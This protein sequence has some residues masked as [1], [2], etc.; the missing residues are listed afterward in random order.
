[1]KNFKFIIPLLLLWIGH[2]KALGNLACLSSLNVDLGVSCQITLTPEEIGVN[3]DPAYNYVLVP[4]T[5]DCYDVGRTITVVLEQRNRITGAFVNSCFS[6]VTITSR[7]IPNPCER[8]NVYCY[9]S[10]NVRLNDEG[11]VSLT[12][13]MLSPVSLEG[14][15]YFVY[16]VSP[17]ILDCGNIGNNEVRLSIISA[18]FP[19]NYC[20]MNVNV[21]DDGPFRPTC[22]N[23]E[24]DGINFYPADLDQIILQPGSL[25]SFTGAYRLTSESGNPPPARFK[26]LLSK[27]KVPDDKDLVVNQQV[28]QFNAKMKNVSG[29]FTIPKNLPAGKYY[30]VSDVYSLNK[31][32]RYACPAVVKSIQIG[33]LQK[34][35][36]SKERSRM[37][38]DL[39]NEHLFYPNPFTA[40][41]N[42]NP[43]MDL[44]QIRTIEVYDLMGTC[45]SK[46][47]KTQ[48]TFDLS[49]L[50]PGTYLIHLS[51]LDGTQMTEKLLKIY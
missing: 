51:L 38:E 32:S 23:I 39:A 34:S 41:I 22:Y 47:D 18:C 17:N 13:E 46:L 16:D 20:I 26:M 4:S 10:V 14:N 29:K 24:T 9:S 6:N 35:A 45:I 11:Y 49:Q 31:K 15:P 2:Y 21:I 27:D 50:H 33:K 7:T 44:D 40:S 19:V 12:P 42:L 25:I 5:F 3:L 36:E 48:T 30:L 28:V 1:M 37:S 8:M 43:G